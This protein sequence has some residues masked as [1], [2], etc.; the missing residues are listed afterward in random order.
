MSGGGTNKEPQRQKPT[1]HDDDCDGNT[2]TT[3]SDYGWKYALGSNYRALAIYRIVLASL[4]ISELVLRFRFLHPFYSDDGTLPLS[5]LLPKVD[6]TYHVLCV[7][8]LSGDLLFQR[9]LLSVQVALAVALLV[10][11]KTRTA[12]FGS[13][14][15][16]L[17]LTLRNTWLNFI[18]DRY[19]HYLL[20]YAVFLP[21]GE[22]YAW[23]P[24][25]EEE[26]ETKK[27]E[28][29][30]GECVLTPATVALKLQVLWIY[31]DAG[32]GKWMDPLGGWTLSAPIPALD[33]YARHTIGAR[34]LYAA[35]TPA[36]LRLL[37]PVVV[38][39]EMLSPV[40]ALLFSYYR[41]RTAVTAVI[42]SICSLH[43]GIAVT[44]RNTFLLSSVA[45]AAWFVFLPSEEGEGRRRG[46]RVTFSAGEVL[47]IFCFISGS[48]WFETM[49]DDC[50]QS[51][52]HVWSTLLHN[53]WNVFVG[54]E[55]YVTWEIAP[56]RLA[57]GQI[58]DVWSKSDTIHWDMPGAG[59][60]CTSTARAGRWR[61]FPY[62]AEL[63]G[64]EGD[65]LWNYLCKQWDEEHN[66][67]RY[68]GRKLLRFNFFMMQADVLPEMGFSRSRKRLIHSHVCAEEEDL[69]EHNIAEKV[70]DDRADEL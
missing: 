49:S 12:A 29:T 37:T 22:I 18:L 50:Q 43:L 27:R 3:N 4:L 55:E 5:I 11:Y 6:A 7:H 60:P 69:E 20:F 39:V 47:T 34:Y 44:I 41:R 52:K 2:T 16:Y 31:L 17:S 32:G 30:L 14:L 33:S 40:L 23:K 46:T 19:F 42:I 62:L 24:S 36:G 53:R 10:G 64:E 58:V 51:V 38:Y 45:C 26:E 68:P 66:V 57:D 21:T 70:K 25:S 15:L 59:A 8:C 54:S 28:S 61:S 67:G 1:P 9:V 13:W 56:G 35:L 65:V 48:V 63:E